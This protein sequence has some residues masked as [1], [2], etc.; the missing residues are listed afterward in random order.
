[1][2]KQL[3]E[4][5]IGVYKFLFKTN[6]RNRIYQKYVLLLIYNGH[7]IL[8]AVHRKQFAIRYLKLGNDRHAG[9]KMIT[10]HCRPFI[11]QIRSDYKIMCGL[12]Q[13]FIKTNMICD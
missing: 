4:M 11:D 2:N 12:N 13:N 7:N 5:S 3:T 8:R 1:M 10:G 9:I 6:E